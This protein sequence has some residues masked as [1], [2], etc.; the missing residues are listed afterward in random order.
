[1]DFERVK[2]DMKGPMVPMSTP[3]KSSFELDLEGLR[4][5]ARFYV[6]HGVVTGKATL[7]CATA[8]GECP[9]FNVPD[10]E[11]VMDVVASEVRGKVPLITSSQ[12]CSIDTV[13]EMS[14][15][16]K[17]KGYVCVQ[18]SPP[19]YYGTSDDEV[20]R[21]YDL[22]AK[23]VDI[24]IMVYNTTWLRILGG[25]GISTKLIDR[26]LNIPNV[27]AAKWSSPDWY[28][29]MEVMRKYSDRVAIIDNNY[30]GLGRLYGA[31]G[32]LSVTSEFATEYG[33]NLWK[34][35]GTGNMKKILDELWK[36]QIP[37]YQWIGKV[38]EAGINGEGVPVKAAIE[39]VGLAAGPA[40][41]PYDHGLPEN[42][43]NELRQILVHA[44]LKD[45]NGK[46]LR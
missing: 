45:I 4:K 23:A 37:Y 14:Q 46:T 25:Q 24:G 6:D 18:L 3:L 2:E 43:K 15:F 28:T 1:M 9:S 19:Y 35:L 21:F 34:T 33:L 22:V 10:R 32:Y 42:L 29:W 17:D 41:P 36:L 44:G 7:M 12:D 26:L 5:N 31:S 39:M 13:V 27:I 8:G 11:K 40:K 20:Y 38:E 16:A 30:H